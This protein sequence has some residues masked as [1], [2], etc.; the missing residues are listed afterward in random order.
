M[1][2]VNEQTALRTVSAAEESPR[3]SR[4]R[5][6]QSECFMWGEAT[7]GVWS[8]RT[9]RLKIVLDAR[10]ILEGFPVCEARDHLPDFGDLGGGIGDGRHLVVEHLVVKHLVVEHLVVKHISVK[11]AVCFGRGKTVVSETNVWVGLGMVLFWV[12]E[13]YLG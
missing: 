13:R 11:H 6:G 9:A 3:R 4:P 1:H 10:R 12:D 8:F 2:P 7:R 5:P